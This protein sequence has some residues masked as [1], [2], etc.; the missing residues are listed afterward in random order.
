M[1][2]A[3]YTD[4]CY[5]HATDDGNLKARCL[6]KGHCIFTKPITEHFAQQAKDKKTLVGVLTDYFAGKTNREIRARWG[7]SGGYIYKKLARV[8]MSSRPTAKVD[9]QYRGIGQA[10]TRKLIPYAGKEKADDET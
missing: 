8:G 10:V 6:A 3:D 1:K 4:Q 2:Q 9:N 5:C 7:V